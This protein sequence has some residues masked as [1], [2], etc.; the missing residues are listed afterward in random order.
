MP[1][2]AV[3]PYG[4]WPSPVSAASLVSGAVGI[5]E[6]HVDGADVWWAE[7]RPDE[8]GR[9]AVMRWRDGETQEITPPHA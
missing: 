2:A 7:S 9:T 3:T 8:A 5:S 4:E 1:D 6:V